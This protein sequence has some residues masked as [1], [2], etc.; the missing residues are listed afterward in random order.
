MELFAS[1]AP[2]L[3]ACFMKRIRSVRAVMQVALNSLRQRR[4]SSRSTTAG[5]YSADHA[6]K[7]LAPAHWPATTLA[8]PSALLLITSIRFRIMKMCRT[9]IVNFVKIASLF[10]QN[11]N[12]LTSVTSAS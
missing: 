7:S 12:Q 3:I 1:N 4:H 9:I 5:Q 10:A 2:N 6:L 8:Q 11:V